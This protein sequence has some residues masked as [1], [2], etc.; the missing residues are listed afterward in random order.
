VTTLS[1]A[2][3][4]AARALRAADVPDPMTD[5]RALLAHASGLNPDRLTLHLTDPLCAAAATLFAALIQ[6]RALRAPVSH[7]IGYRLF[8]GRRFTVTP[9]VLDPRPETE[10][11]ICAAL[12][13]PF[14]TILDLGTGSGAILLTL[15]AERTDATGLG[16]DASMPALAVARANA[17]AIGLTA[18]AQFADGSWFVPVTGQYDLITSNP[19]YIAEHEMAGLSPDVRL[20]EPHIALTPGG[21]GLDAYR[22]IAEGVVAHLA[23]SGRV[24]LEIGPTQGRDVLALLAAHGL[25]GGSILP[26]LDGRDRVVVA[27]KP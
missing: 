24:M 14:T 8:W 5:A 22:A 27:Q 4:A 6:R 26:D 3:A 23:P 18:R 17:A 15:L 1:A 19:P 12:A 25:P 9:D 10:T 2:L 20:Y 13:A 7:L 16:T 21:D 11:L